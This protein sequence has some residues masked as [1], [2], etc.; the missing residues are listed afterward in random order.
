MKSRPMQV[1]KR[2]IP[3]FGLMSAEFLSLLGNQIAAVALPILVLQFT[4][5]PLITG[6]AGIGSVLPVVLAA[7]VGGRA[8]DKFGA[9][10]VSVTADLLSGLSVAALPLAFLHLEVV[11]PSL[12]FLLVFIGALFDPAGVASRQTLVP[13][14]A[15]LAGKPLER[16]NAYRGSLENGADFFGPILGVAIISL[17]GA[18]NTFFVNAVSFLICLILFSATV[19]NK[20]RRSAGRVDEGMFSGVRFI[21]AHQQLRTL[22]LIGLVTSFVLLPFLALLLPVLA[23]EK[24]GSPTLL[25]ICLSVFGAAATLGALSFAMVSRYVSRSVIYYSGLLI[26]AVAILL[27][28]SA[29]SRIGV[30]VAVALAGSVLGAGNPLEQTV[31]HEETPKA[32]AG[33]VFTSLTA[34]RFVAGPFGLLFAGVMMEFFFLELIFILMGTILA[35][36][37]LAGWYFLPLHDRGEIYADPG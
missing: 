18:I 22:A 9:W 26:T 35:S 17:I 10:S 4:H 19:P 21:F 36:V 27:S 8:I 11:P 25:G 6:L 5:S 33:Q 23:T 30:I 2:T 28:A 7:F 12:I 37:S 16:V 34:V 14:L 29:Q 32:I 15:R 1:A 24:F 31:L 20:L 3:L 13:S